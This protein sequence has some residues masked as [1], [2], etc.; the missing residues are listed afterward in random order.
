MSYTPVSIPKVNNG[1]VPKPKIKVLIGRIRDVAVFPEPGANGVE[2]STDLTM[3]DG[4]NLIEL[5]VTP[6]TI[7]ITQPTEGDPDSKGY[8]PKIEMSRPGGLDLTFEEFAEKNVN[9]DLF[10]I[11]QYVGGVKKIA[12]YP[13]NPLHMSIES[14]DNN[15][16]D[17]NIVTLESALRGRRICQ[18]SGVVPSV[19]GSG[20]GSGS[21]TGA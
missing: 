6:S 8:K 4:A 16:S 12:G 17:V 14:T 2:I 5:E 13:G 11:V 9:E 7:A 1:G 3:K 15:E 18:Y 10:C 20:S 19:S 21:G